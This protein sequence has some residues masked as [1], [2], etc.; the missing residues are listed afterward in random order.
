MA[1]IEDHKYSI[2]ESFRECF[3]VEIQARF[4]AG[5]N[6]GLADEGPTAGPASLAGLKIARERDWTA[7]EVGA[8]LP[9]G[10]DQTESEGDRK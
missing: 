1:C 10:S 4:L 5:F 9:A 8:A 7:P 3:T 2:E 6:D